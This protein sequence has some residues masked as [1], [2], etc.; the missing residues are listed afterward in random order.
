VRLVQRALVAPIS[1]ICQL[2][3]IEQ[4]VQL[5]L[6]MAELLGDA[7]QIAPVLLGIGVADRL[8]DQVSDGD[9]GSP[10]AERQS[11]LAIPTQS[12]PLCVQRLKRVPTQSGT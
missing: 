8:V 12:D 6:R 5:R 4:H 3:L 7:A 1:T 2:H 9:R 11:E 10:S